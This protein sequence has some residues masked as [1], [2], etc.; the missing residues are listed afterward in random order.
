MKAQTLYFFLLTVFM[1]VSCEMK[2]RVL[3]ND[4]S[5][6]TNVKYDYNQSLTVD[7][8]GRYFSGEAEI[9]VYSLEKARY[10]SVHKGQ[11]ILVQVVEPFLY[12]EQVKND[13]GGEKGSLNVLKSNYFERFTTG[14]YDYSL[15]TSAFTPLQYDT[16]QHSIKVS[17]SVQDWCG[18]TYVQINNRGSLNLSMN[19]YFQSEGDSSYRIETT[20]Q[21]DEI[22]NLIRLSKD[23]LPVDTF[24]IVPK[25]TFLSTNHVSPKT[26]TAI[27]G[28]SLDTLDN[29]VYTISMPELKR[30][31]KYYF[32][33]S[34]ENLIT[35]ME[36]EYPTVF[37]G[38]IRKST[39][40]L[41]SVQ[42]M[43]YWEL[44]SPSFER[45]RAKMKLR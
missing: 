45:L 4:L 28:L 2:A 11:A 19:S 6:L 13:R 16:L 1:F 15:M 40:K 23:V 10:D 14:V 38:E 21:E 42:K 24:L 5:L 18:Q 26:Y 27:G 35:Q 25:A 39:A 44:N 30:T 20:W 33:T 29:M 41:K 8:G 31:V 36:E 7:L 12:E 34:K 9:M 17:A 32:D 3:Q 43:P 37:D 22:M